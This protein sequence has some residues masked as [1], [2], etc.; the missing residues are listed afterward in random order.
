MKTVILKIIL[1][2]IPVFIF[3]QAENIDS[4][5]YYPAK[6]I[7]ETKYEKEHYPK[8][9]KSQIKTVGNKVILGEMKSLEFNDQSNEKTK[10]IL[11]SG[12]LDPYWINGSYHLKI[13]W[14]DELT[15]LNPNSQTKRFKFWI[16]YTGHKNPLLNS[17]N[18]HEYYLEFYNAK[19][20]ENTT[21]INFMENAHL[22][23]IKYGGIIL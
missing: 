5:K 23:L 14:I 1:I 11:K 9:L 12:L 18:P 4:G 22:T 17:V 13:G 15:L 7:F 16:F 8:F 3:G 20:T 21:F 10:I 19:A 6:E 2:I